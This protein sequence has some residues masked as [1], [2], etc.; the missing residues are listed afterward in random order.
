MRGSNGMNPAPTSWQQAPNQVLSQLA[1]TWPTQRVAQEPATQQQA[2]TQPAPTV[3][4]SLNNLQLRATQQAAC[5]ALCQLALTWPTELVAPRPATQQQASE[6][7]AQTVALSRDH[8]RLGAHL[9]DTR[10]SSASHTA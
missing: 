8:L 9:A 7:P 4:L 1:L 10:G 2:S 5:A 3:T 6:Q